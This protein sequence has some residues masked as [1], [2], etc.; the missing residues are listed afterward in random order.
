M[1]KSIYICSRKALSVS[2]EKRLYEICRKL[3]PD[4]IK[5]SEPRIL[6]NGD[7]AYGVMNPTRTLLQKGNSLLMGQIFE[8]DKNWDVPLLE[9]PDGSYALF[10]DGKEYCEIVTDP[11][12]SRTIWFYFDETI[13]I[14]STS[15]RAII[16]FIGSFEFDERVIPWMLSTG[17]LGPAYSWDKRLKRIP[18]DSSVILNKI[19]WET[20]INSNPIKFKIVKRS[21]KEHERLLRESL[22]TTFKSLNLDFHNWVLL[23]SG[24]YDS[25]GI[26]C[27][28]LN[29][30]S[31]DIQSLRT[32]TWGLEACLNVKG[33]DAYVA[34]ALANK[35]NVSH[36]YY[37]TDLSDEPIDIIIKRFFLLGEGCV[38]QLSA[39]MDGFKIW[40]TLFE[41]GVQGIIRGDVAFGMASKSLISSHLGVKLLVSSTVCS[42]FSNLRDYKK[43]GFATQEVPQYLNRRNGETLNAWGNRIYQEYRLPV[44][45]SALTDLKLSYV[46]QIN[47]LLS[48]TILQCVRQWPDH[49]RYGKTL[50][51]E[52]VNSL[53]PEV[54]YAA[55]PA[56]A[57]DRDVLRLIPI[58]NLLKNELSS[59][60]AQT[61]LPAEF[62]D[63]VLKNIESE[64][65]ANTIKT[66]SFSLSSFI[67]GMVPH[68]IKNAIRKVL[69][70]KIDPNML[71]FRVLIVIK[72]NKILNDDCRNN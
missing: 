24:G 40:K 64:G 65:Q 23:L 35:L 57:A 67:S 13:F 17:S 55:R 63:F 32:I 41:D 5:P 39:Y 45:L 31:K 10:R 46:E 30:Y 62:L 25:R 33:N 44:I 51:K 26:L 36:K 59:S 53:S 22:N 60:E 42:D 2:V 7:I 58:V 71:A 19:K 66:E 47:P 11:V 50:F 29:N 49:L 72:M 28:L 61:L 21:D 1:S 4:N 69:L 37:H 14:A 43:Y 9:F 48:R 68:F 34:Q 18:A 27:L 15:Q 12:A 52:V 54:D 70:P 20:H 56:D 16:M 3:A 8:K 6:V 38:D